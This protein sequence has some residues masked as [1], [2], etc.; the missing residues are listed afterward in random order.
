MTR[1]LRGST[2]A[3]RTRRLVTVLGINLIALGALPGSGIGEPGEPMSATTVMMAP[4]GYLIE[5]RYGADPIIQL[6]PRHAPREW[7]D[8]KEMMF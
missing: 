3:R 4:A 8:H 7:R 5:G 6:V 1:L 2:F